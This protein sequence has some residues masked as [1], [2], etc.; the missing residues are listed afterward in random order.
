V[1]GPNCCIAPWVPANPSAQASRAGGVQ[2]AAGRNL[3]KLR[4]FYNRGTL[5]SIEDVARFALPYW[6][7]VLVVNAGDSEL[8]AMLD[9]ERHAHRAFP[10]PGPAGPAG[11]A[12]EGRTLIAELEARRAEGWDYLLVPQE[13]F[14][15]LDRHDAIGQHLAEEYRIVR[16]DE[17]CRIFALEKSVSTDL[18]TAPDGMPLPPPEMRGLVSG[19]AD[20][21]YFFTSGARTAGWIAEMLAANG[22]SIEGMEFLDFGCGCGRVTRHWKDTPRAS[23][24]GSDYN[25]YL[26]EWCRANLA[27]AE[28]ELNTNAPP[29]GYTGGKFDLVYAISVFTHL[30]EPLQRVWLEELVR[31]L[32]PGG[33]LL[34]TVHGS[35]YLDWMDAD[36]TGRFEAGELVV[37]EPGLSGTTFCAT[38]HPER[39]VR[40]TLGRGMELLDYAP[41]PLRDAHQDAVLFR[42]P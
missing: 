26:I 40:E 25:P 27:F 28:F 23:V 16:A 22:S 41:A 8:P 15:W 31:L 10:D 29:L 2:A 42:K 6:A 38:F 12:D 17:S 11:D 5:S 14:G 3:R 35:S 18:E 39:Y 4:A 36:E 30:R 34:F 24:N 32:R 33:L 9:R 7:S 1:L 13:A 19:E 37:R 21:D 20:P